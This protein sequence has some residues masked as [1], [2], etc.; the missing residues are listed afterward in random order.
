MK[1]IAQILLALLVVFMVGPV[2]LIGWLVV[3]VL[4]HLA[5]S[6]DH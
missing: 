2:F 1:L 3:M 6:N 5:S 4:I